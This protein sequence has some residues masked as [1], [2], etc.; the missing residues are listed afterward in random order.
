VDE[1]QHPCRP[2]PIPI[3][4]VSVSHVQPLVSLTS[5]PIPSVSVSHVQPLVSLTS[6]P[7][8]S[9]SVSH[10]QPAN[11]SPISP[12]VGPCL[13]H[14]TSLPASHFDF[15]LP[16][17]VQG[18][19]VAACTPCLL[20]SYLM[21]TLPTNRPLPQTQGSS[22]LPCLGGLR[23]AHTPRASACQTRA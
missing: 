8:P 7:I 19:Q 17:A 6:I 2:N 13:H 5:I 22:C 10:V 11:I 20:R 21:H 12:H 4:S 18:A 1:L 23:S 3:P 14:P 15:T 16:S 9:V